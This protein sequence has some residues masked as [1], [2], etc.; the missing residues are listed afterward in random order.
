MIKTKRLMIIVTL[1]TV[2]AMFLGSILVEAAPPQSTY[3]YKYTT[4]PIRAPL[5][6]QHLDWAVLNNAQ[7]TQTIRVTI[8]QLDFDNAKSYWIYGSPFEFTLDSGKTMHN[9]NQAFPGYLFEIVV[10]TNSKLVFPSAEFWDL[11]QASIPGSEIV[12]AE[13]IRSMS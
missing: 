7:N 9:A 8:Y 5:G 3:S 10:E 12:S 11:N 13:F 4:G 2:A 1:L 6:T